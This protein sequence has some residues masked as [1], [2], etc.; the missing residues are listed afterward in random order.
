MA[1]HI[2]LTDFDDEDGLPPPRPPPSSSDEDEAADPRDG[3]L[4]MQSEFESADSV[5]EAPKSKHLQVRLL[6]LWVWVAEWIS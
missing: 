3:K 2:F 1:G 6:V 4:N 5:E